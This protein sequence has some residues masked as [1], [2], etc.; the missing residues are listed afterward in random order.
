MYYYVIYVPG[1]RMVVDVVHDDN[2]PCIAVTIFRSIDHHLCQ[3][4]YH[5]NIVH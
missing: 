4:H 2:V 3:Q 5:R 1:I